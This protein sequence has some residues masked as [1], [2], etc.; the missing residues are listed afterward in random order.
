MGLKKS[1]HNVPEDQWDLPVGFNEKG[2][3]V[4]LREYANTKTREIFQLSAIPHNQL[5]ELIQLRIEKQKEYPELFM[6]GKGKVDKAR[7]LKELK[8]E[9]DIG[10]YIIELE[11]RVI[12]MVKEEVKK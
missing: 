4:T 9:S 8:K 12:N 11:L 3:I 10:E 2:D 7:A 6:L 1:P 5:K